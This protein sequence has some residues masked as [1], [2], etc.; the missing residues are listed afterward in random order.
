MKYLKRYNESVDKCP[1]CNGS[2]EVSYEV[3]MWGKMDI[4]KCDDC[5]GTGDIKKYKVIKDIEDF[6][7]ECESEIKSLLKKHGISFGFVS[8]EINKYSNDDDDIENI[9]VTTQ[10]HSTSILNKEFLKEIDVIYY[11]YELSF[12]T[13]NNLY[14]TVIRLY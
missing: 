4:K 12:D 8:S 3:N 1:T 11:D 14:L 7:E 10:I 9:E 6:K 2:G 13:Y 5:N